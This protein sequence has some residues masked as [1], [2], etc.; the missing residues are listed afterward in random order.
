ME[1]GITFYTYGTSN[2]NCDKM[3]EQGK[4]IPL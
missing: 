2:K 4:A 3:Y 1:A